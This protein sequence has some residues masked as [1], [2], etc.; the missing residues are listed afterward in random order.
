[1]ENEYLNYQMEELKM[2]IKRTIGGAQLPIGITVYILKDILKEM[3]DLYYNRVQEEQA[4]YAAFQKELQEM[5]NQPI[6]EES[7]QEEENNE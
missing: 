1:M 3:E 7:N 2:Y 6:E 4:R 5:E